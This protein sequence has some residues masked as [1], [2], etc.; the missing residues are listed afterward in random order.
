[1]LRR[2]RKVTDSYKVLEI[3]F[4]ESSLAKR[5]RFLPGHRL[6][7]SLQ[8]D[9]CGEELGL[10]KKNLRYLKDIILTKAAS[11]FSNYFPTTQVWQIQQPAEVRRDHPG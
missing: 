3:L 4:Q 2:N 1:M 7:F 8:V 10:W 5:R 6:V 9:C 11:N